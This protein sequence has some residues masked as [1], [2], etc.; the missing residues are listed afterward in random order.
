MNK[1]I[2][3]LLQE[4]N[5]IDQITPLIE[6]LCENGHKIFLIKTMR[7]YDYNNDNNLDYLLEKFKNIKVYDIFFNKNNIFKFVFEKFH[8]YNNKTI[9]ENKLLFRILRG[10]FYRIL[11]RIDTIDTNMINEFY[12]KLNINNTVLVSELTN[13]DHN[14]KPFLE[15]AKKNNIYNISF[16]HGFEVLTNTLLGYEDW[17]IKNNILKNDATTFSNKIVIFNSVPFQRIAKEDISKFIQLPS[18][19]F[20]TEWIKKITSKH[21]YNIDTQKNKL[22]IVFMLSSPGY[23]IWIEEQF[24]T[25]KMLLED[26]NICLTVKIHPRDSSMKRELLKVKK[27]NLIIADN[28]VKSSFLVDWADIVMTIGSGIIIEAIIKRKIIF[29]IKYLHC[30][31]IVVE[32][33]K[34]IIHKIT[35]RDELLILID[36]YKTNQ[37]EKLDEN[38]RTEFLKDYI[39][40]DNFE[41]N[42]QKY[43][44]LFNE[45]I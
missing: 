19:R 4:H 39:L 14:Y 34:N 30:N 35:T 36:K 6:I 12:K 7:L 13:G 18:L 26:E 11:I 17:S 32:D 8:L 20:S 43:L 42:K 15:E 23:N 37:I 3:F 22:K 24:R 45:N 10:V 2:I 16:T 31:S 1:N 44:N 5:S 33:T 29:Y 9:I 21:K 28:K 40:N 38:E 25:I 27:E 41:E